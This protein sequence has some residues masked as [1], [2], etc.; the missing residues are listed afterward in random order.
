MFESTTHHNS[1]TIR[2]LARSRAFQK[3]R[4][5]EEVYELFRKKR[6]CE[7]TTEREVRSITLMWESRKKIWENELAFYQEWKNWRNTMKSRLWLIETQSRRESKRIEKLQALKFD[8]L[9]PPTTESDA[10]PEDLSSAV[11]TALASHATGKY[12]ADCPSEGLWGFS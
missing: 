3:N 11:A 5:K 7:E 12:P 4:P 10:E 2:R 8:E 6:V 1:T 9:F